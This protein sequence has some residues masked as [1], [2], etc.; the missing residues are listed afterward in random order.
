M[1]GDRQLVEDAKFAAQAQMR[2]LVKEL[3]PDPKGYFSGAYYHCR[4]PGR[5]DRSVGSFFVL[6]TGPRAGF[7]RDQA[8][9]EQGDVIHLVQ[10][11][12][13]LGPGDAIRWL[14]NWTGVRSLSGPALMAKQAEWREEAARSSHEDEREF[15]EQRRRAKGLLLNGKPLCPPAFGAM[16]SPAWRYFTEVRAINFDRIGG[17]PS[18]LRWIPAHR[19]RESG[20]ELPCIVAGIV[21]QAGAIIGVHRTWLRPD[22]SD[23]APV[24]PNRKMWP[25]GIAGGVTW[26]SRGGSKHSALEAGRRGETGIVIYGEGIEDGLTAA[27]GEPEARVAAILSLYNLADLSDLACA[28]GYVVL[29]DNDWTKPEAVAA[30]DEGFARI[31][32]F[33]KPC[34]WISSPHGKDFN[35][36]AQAE[37]AGAL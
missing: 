34:E 35:D 9:G 23:K 32:S 26:L 36:L 27:M 30:F 10:L 4:N 15:D 24:R 16:A 20:Q 22:G 14:A 8:T 5:A 2:A 37:A 31:R 29:R 33:G 17:V 13:K 18:L 21:D 6:L 25:R 19:H 11:A 3:L 7:W 12:L 1:S 28:A